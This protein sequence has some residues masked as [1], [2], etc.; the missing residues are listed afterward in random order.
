MKKH[1]GRK[2][3]ED[4]TRPVAP[5]GGGSRATPSAPAHGERTQAG[6]GVQ[7]CLGRVV[8]LGDEPQAGC[9]EAFG[10]DPKVKM[11]HGRS[12]AIEG[13]SHLVPRD[14]PLASG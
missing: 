10:L 14:V 8:L 4:S 2:E 9:T 6:G 11:N 5:R 1:H 13:L 7:G 12:R 3:E